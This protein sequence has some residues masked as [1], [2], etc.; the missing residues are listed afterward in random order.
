[1]SNGAYSSSDF[2][3][4][5]LEARAEFYSQRDVAIGE[6]FSRFHQSVNILLHDF[7]L[8]GED[9][10]DQ[11]LEDTHD[12]GIDFF[13]VS[14]EEDPKIFAIQVKDHLS[15]AK[16][17]QREAIT[18]LVDEMRLLM[19]R[20]RVDRNWDERRQLRYADLKAAKNKTYTIKFVLLL[21]G[22]A[23]PAI[24][25]DDFAI[26]KFE[27]E[28]EELLVID[29]QNLVELH[30]EQIAPP[31]PDVELVL[32]EG[33]WHQVLHDGINTIAMYL[34]ALEY[35]SGTRRHKS[36]IFRL[37][38]RLF[39]G[40]SNSFN[41]KML[42]TLKKEDERGKFH[43]L[44]NGITAVCDSINQD[45]LK[46]TMNDFQ[47]VN[48]CQS[49]ETLWKAFLDP[50]IDLKDV[51]IP[52]RVIETK[53]DHA[54][55]KRISETTN[56][57]TAISSSDLVANTDLQLSLKESLEG[58]AKPIFYEARRGSWL[59]IRPT[60]K[61]RYRVAPGEWS[62]LSVKNIRH[63]KLKELAQAL[64]AVCSSPHAAKEQISSLFNSTDEESNYDKI[65]AKSWTSI[66]QVQLV[67][68]LFKYVSAKD[69]WLP[70]SFTNDEEK[71]TFSNMAGLGR[72][73][74]TFLI[75]QQW[76]QDCSEAYDPSS[77]EPI[78]ISPENSELILSE[79]RPRV[80][81]LP[82][83]AVNTLLAVKNKKST[84]ARALLRQKNN[85]ADIQEE[86][87]RYVDVA[88]MA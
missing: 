27:D 63:I 76:R 9:I 32:S 33:Q 50:E 88:R 45:G 43:L 61:E 73:Y 10:A 39:L 52:L 59:Q 8:S 21:T 2:H 35:V 84:D 4:E 46:L 49:T 51:L 37:N 34:P 48:G 36:R 31:R 17:K 53:G 85:R 74:I 14:D 15:L 5:C 81:K 66:S 72:F 54:L 78:L 87:R 24:T 28:I 67:V 56:S 3:E 7:D 12:Q 71:K 75:Y 65:V 69:N 44:N 82:V 57:Q 20:Q 77:D 16:D 68:E 79:F 26:D 47:V 38:P 60:G 55:A 23:T 62:D 25:R 70:S 29:I 64:L 40:K 13:F 83:L 41:K 30:I 80:G 6:R 11:V 42:E 18:K 58:L 86:F 22:G 19:S 1:M